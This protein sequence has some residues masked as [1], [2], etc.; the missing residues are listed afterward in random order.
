[1]TTGERICVDHGRVGR[2]ELREA[3][4]IH[5]DGLPGFPEAR[6]FALLR[7]DERSFFAWLACLDDPGLAF[8]VVDP[9]E[10]FIDYA[11]ALGAEHLVLVGAKEPGEACLLAIA[12]LSRGGA[13]VNLAAPLLVNVRTRQAAQVVLAGERW[14]VRAMLPVARPEGGPPS[15]WS[16]APR[17]AALPPARMRVQTESNPQT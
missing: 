10:L 9:L 8:T 4:V 16:A 17:P 14:P 3:D 11:P 2:I 13:F 5:F 7:H 15:A 1:M 12:N 6:R